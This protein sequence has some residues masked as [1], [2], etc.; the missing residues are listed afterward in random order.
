MLSDISSG[1][2]SE[3]WSVCSKTVLVIIS[4]FLE[5]LLFLFPNIYLLPN[6]SGCSFHIVV[7]FI[8]LNT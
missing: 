1:N 5:L 7:N 6:E 2:N 3:F 8:R 4:I